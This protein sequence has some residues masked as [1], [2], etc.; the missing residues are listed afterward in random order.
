M[1]PASPFQNTMLPE[2][3]RERD[4][5]SEIFETDVLFAFARE[6]AYR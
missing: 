2:R 1:F 5:F 6:Q 4:K 3:E